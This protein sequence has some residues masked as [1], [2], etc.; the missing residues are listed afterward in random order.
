MGEPKGQELG[1]KLSRKKTKIEKSRDEM[2][3]SEA[4]FRKRNQDGDSVD[5]VQ[6]NI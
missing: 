5:S 1:T 6:I 2:S 4:R 3:E